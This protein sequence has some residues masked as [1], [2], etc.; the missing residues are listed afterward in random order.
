MCLSFS[1]RANSVAFGVYTAQI[2]LEE[3]K[4]KAKSPFGLAS[5]SISRTLLG[6]A[7]VGW[8]EGG[9]RTHVEITGSGGF[10]LTRRLS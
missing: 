10:R 7:G 2:S 9:A 5:P 1:L 8:G 3:T 4:K 6:E